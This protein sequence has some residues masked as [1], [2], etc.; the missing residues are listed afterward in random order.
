MLSI[1]HS[2]HNLRGIAIPTGFEPVTYGIQAPI[3]YG[4]IMMKFRGEKNRKSSKKVG[5]A[6]FEPAT[7]RL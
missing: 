6:G 3:L 5:P 7:W 2:Y 1:K 4:Y